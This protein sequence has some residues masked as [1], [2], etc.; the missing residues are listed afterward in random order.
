MSSYPCSRRDPSPRQCTADGSFRQSASTGGLTHGCQH[1]H[2]GAQHTAQSTHTSGEDEPFLSGSVC[3]DMSHRCDQTQPR[4]GYRHGAAPRRVREKISDFFMCH[5]FAT[6]L[7]PSGAEYPPRK[8][9]TSLRTARRVSR[10][11]LLWTLTP[12]S[13]TTT[14]LGHHVIEELEDNAAHRLAAYRAVEKH[15]GVAACRRSERAGP[16]PVRREG[17]RSGAW[18]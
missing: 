7:G 1:T 9:S 16:A 10:T 11:S 2:A 3:A 4:K 18:W 17:A 6:T 8:H 12:R 5:H 15:L 13:H 14:D